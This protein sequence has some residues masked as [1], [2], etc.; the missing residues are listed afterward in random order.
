MSAPPASISAVEAVEHV[1]RV[2][3]HPLVGREH[4]RDRAR[5]LQGVDVGP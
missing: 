1:V 4:Q 5:A 2:V 3:G